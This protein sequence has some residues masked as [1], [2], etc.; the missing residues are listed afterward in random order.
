MPNKNK[1]CSV[2]LFVED[3]NEN[4][5]DENHYAAESK[6]LPFKST[7]QPRNP[8]RYDSSDTEEEDEQQPVHDNKQSPSH[9]EDNAAPFFGLWT[10]TFFLKDKD[11]RL[12]GNK[13]N[14]NRF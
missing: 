10:D 7:L 2:L 5:V 14:V 6:N 3:K 11:S 12:K 4:K 1:N 8:F 13:D 9:E